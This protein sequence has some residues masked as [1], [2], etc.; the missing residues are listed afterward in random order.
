MSQTSYVYKPNDPTVLYGI[1]ATGN[2]STGFIHALSVKGVV[3][4]G[5]DFW[6]PALPRE[7]WRHFQRRNGSWGLVKAFASVLLLSLLIPL[8][9]HA[10]EPCKVN[11]NSASPAQLALLIQTGPVLAGKIAA[12]RTAG[13]LDAAKLDAVSGIGVKWL[14]YNEP[15]VAYSGET[16][17]K[18]KLKKPAAPKP[19]AEKDGAQ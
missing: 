9:T 5:I 10:A 4:D 17:C 3:D 11:V 8:T 12:A 2:R 7:T 6:H 15:H 18:D 19:E 16:T 14:E 1:G 13:P